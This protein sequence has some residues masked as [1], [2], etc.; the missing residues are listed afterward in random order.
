MKSFYSDEKKE[1]TKSSW[2]NCALRDEEA[3][4][5]VSIGHCQAIAVAAA[6]AV[7]GTYAFIYCTKWRSGQVL[8][9]L[10]SLTDRL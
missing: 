9:I 1:V 6:V 7:E 4:Y 3:V 10:Y 8:P 5:W 2:L